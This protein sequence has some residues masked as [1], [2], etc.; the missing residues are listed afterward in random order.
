M[1]DPL[2]LLHA[3][4]LDSRMWDGLAE[5]VSRRARLVTPD[6]RGL[7]TATLPDTEAPPSLDDAADDVLAQLDR[8]GIDRAVVGGCSMGGYL[9]M[10]VLRKA[11]ERVSG[12][13]FI[14]TKASADTDEAR[15]NRLTTAERAMREGHQGWLAENMMSVLV[16]P[17][18]HAERPEV[19]ARVR[20]LV[21]AQP[22]AGIAWAL[23]AMAD[24]PDSTETLRAADVPALVIMGAEDQLT[25][26]AEATAMVDALPNATL[27]TVQGAG[28]LSPLEDPES[29]AKTVLDWLP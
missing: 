28:H 2:V 19:L 6:Q 24:R 27:A 25:P 18:T 9:T 16:G 4:P 10:A 21:D 20:E 11:P 13:V 12:L 5:R 26:M 14:D 7:G 17:T 23:R 3:F 15:A 1:N 29:V 22:S 8:L